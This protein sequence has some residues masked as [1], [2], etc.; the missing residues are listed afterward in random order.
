M[1]VDKELKPI[2]DAMVNTELSSATKRFFA[3]YVAT[4]MSDL[5]DKG[6]SELGGILEVSSEKVRAAE[7]R[8]LFVFASKVLPDDRIKK[9]FCKTLDTLTQR[10]D[11]I[12]AGLLNK[13]SLLHNNKDVSYYHDSV[14]VFFRKELKLAKELI[15]GGRYRNFYDALDRA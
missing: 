4:I 8:R 5:Y 3:F 15:S 2:V 9:M 11:D 1:E 7:E 13:Y 6:V 14:S 10:Q 12:V